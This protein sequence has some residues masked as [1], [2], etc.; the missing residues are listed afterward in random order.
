MVKMRHLSILLVLFAVKGEAKSNL[1]LYQ[2][3]CSATTLPQSIL[4]LQLGAGC[5]TSDNICF[6]MVMSVAF[7]TLV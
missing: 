2:E 1:F 5:F 4:F 7:Q 3:Q 6:Q